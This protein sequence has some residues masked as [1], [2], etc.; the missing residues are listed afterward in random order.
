MKT[1]KFP[2]NTGPEQYHISMEFHANKQ[3][4]LLLLVTNTNSLQD[5]ILGIGIYEGIVRYCTVN[6]Q[7]IRSISNYM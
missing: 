7:L 1:L 2:S 5:P 3:Y 4:G 6:N